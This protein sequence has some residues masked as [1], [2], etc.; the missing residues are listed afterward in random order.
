MIFIIIKLNTIFTQ[1]RVAL[2]SPLYDLSSDSV[3]CSLLVLLPGVRISLNVALVNILS[4]CVLISGICSFCQPDH[5]Q[6][7][8]THSSYTTGVFSCKDLFLEEEEIM[9]TFPETCINCPNLLFIA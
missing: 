5:R 8:P 1:T 6:E 3:T 4:D 2:S 9:V 7:I